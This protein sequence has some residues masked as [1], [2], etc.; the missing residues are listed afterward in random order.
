[1]GLDGEGAVWICDYDARAMQ[2]IA[3]DF[4][5]YLRKQCLRLPD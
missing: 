3:P 2:A 1:M 4:E 5:S